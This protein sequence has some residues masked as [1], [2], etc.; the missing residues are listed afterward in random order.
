M[1]HCGPQPSWLEAAVYLMWC[2]VYAVCH[3]KT[4]SLHRAAGHL[5][6]CILGCCTCLF[7][8]KLPSVTVTPKNRERHWCCFTLTLIWLHCPKLFPGSRQTD[9]FLCVLRSYCI[10]LTTKL[11]P[12]AHFT[13]SQS[14]FSC[15]APVDPLFLCSSTLRHCLKI[16]L[17][18]GKEN[19]LRS[20]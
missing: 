11:R 17:W 3:T 20:F 14:F 7:Q 16:M 10:K 13:L 18:R 5:H 1:C 12:K 8:G 6:S 4:A 19:T 15:C 2:A 9:A